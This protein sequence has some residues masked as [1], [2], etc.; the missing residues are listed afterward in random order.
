M[1]LPKV[2]FIF[3]EY[4]FK[5]MVGGAAWK[6][7]FEED[8]R[9]GTNILEA[10]TQ[11]TLENNYFAWV[12]EYMKENPGSTLKTEYNV[13]GDDNATNDDRQLFCGDLDHV[14]IAAPQIGEDG[15]AN[16]YKLLIDEDEDSE[17]IEQARKDNELVRK[18]VMERIA[19]GNHLRLNK[20]MREKLELKEGS[21]PSNEGRA[22]TREARKRKRKSM[23]EMKR[24]T[25]V[26]S[27]KK[28]KKASGRLGGG[29][30]KAGSL[31]RTW[32]RKSRAT[33]TPDFTVSGRRHTRSSAK[34]S[35]VQK[36]QRRT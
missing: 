20:D 10:Y 30:M 11:A 28:R 22:G 23:K 24:F 14:Q 34:P 4:F 16:E 19:T 18:R 35:T 1:A 21:V 32:Q 8:V 15:T 6:K 12:Y 9:F 26:G 7:R 31:W 33:W 29:W 13:A 3:Y 17:E 27:T 2:M 36:G 25:G 5:A